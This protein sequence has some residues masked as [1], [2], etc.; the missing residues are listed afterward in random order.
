MPGS[1]KAIIH[2]IGDRGRSGNHAS[3]SNDPRPAAGID[4]LTFH[5]LRGTAIIP[6]AVA[7]CAE[8]EITSV[9]DHSLGDVQRV[10]D[11]L[12]LDR[13]PALAESA[14]RKLERGGTATKS[15]NR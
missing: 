5:D 6:L 12:L 13:D 1:L 14:L 9:T 2:G 11:P 10:L 15:P 7:D 3:E 4:G 8:A